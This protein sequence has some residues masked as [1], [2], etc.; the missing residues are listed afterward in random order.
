M[1]DG[2]CLHSFYPGRVT[3][4]SVLEKTRADGHWR[5]RTV[6]SKGTWETESWKYK[7]R[8]KIGQ[9]ALGS[10]S[11]CVV[12]GGQ[13]KSWDWVRFPGYV[14]KAGGENEPRPDGAG[15]EGAGRQ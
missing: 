11:V 14:G 6:G 8:V 9:R 7:S 2:G 5:R 3:S 13:R 10:V 4:L 15:R 1:R 12:C